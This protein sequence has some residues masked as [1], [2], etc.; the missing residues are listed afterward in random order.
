MIYKSSSV[1]FLER[2]AIFHYF[3]TCQ[4][5]AYAQASIEEE[6]PCHLL[7][8]SVV[9]AKFNKLDFFSPPVMWFVLVHGSFRK[10]WLPPSPIQE[11]E[12]MIIHDDE[13]ESNDRD[14]MDLTTSSAENIQ[15]TC[16]AKKE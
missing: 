11:N 10:P 12:I 3:I 7:I 2:V 1:R 4:N 14:E 15:I 16:I 8:S 6:K 13:E 5:N 9:C